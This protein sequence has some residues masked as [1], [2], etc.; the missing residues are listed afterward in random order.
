MRQPIDTGASSVL[1]HQL[2]GIW[3]TGLMVTGI[4]KTMSLGKNLSQCDFEHY[5]YHMNH[6]ETKPKASR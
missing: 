6:S 5:K 1:L 3:S 2:K 4:G